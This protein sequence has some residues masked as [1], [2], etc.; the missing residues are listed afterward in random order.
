MRP[1]DL[2]ARQLL[3]RN[4]VEERRSRFGH[5]V[6]FFYEGREFLHLHGTKEADIRLGQAAVEELR[7]RL[8]TDSRVRLRDGSSDWVVVNLSRPADV[9]LVLELVTRVLP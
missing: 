8:S 6:A 2:L 5:E 1:D 9:E 3:E 7:E 4:G